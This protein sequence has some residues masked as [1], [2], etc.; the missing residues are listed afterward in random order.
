MTVIKCRKNQYLDDKVCKPCP[1]GSFT[2]QLTSETSCTPNTCAVNEYAANG[3][4]NT[5]GVGTTNVQGGD[6][7]NTTT[8]CE[9][10]LCAVDEYVNNQHQCGSCPAGMSTFG[11]RYTTDV[12]NIKV[13]RHIIC[14]RNQKVVSNECTNCPQGSTAAPGAKASGSDT[15]CLVG[16]CGLNEYVKDN[17]CFSMCTWINTCS[18]YT[19]DQLRHHLHRQRVV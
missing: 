3:V 19:I 4:C 13:C 18:K 16:K 2:P 10:T 8:K 12:S 11:K 17:E 7:T 5:C 9:T 1:L 14:Q 15:T 6:L